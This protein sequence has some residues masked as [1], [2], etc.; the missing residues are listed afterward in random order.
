MNSI[1]ALFNNLYFNSILTA[2]VVFFTAQVANYGHPLIGVI[3]STFP[4]GIMSFLTIDNSK[5]RNDFL[6]H[7]VIGNIIISIMWMIISYFRH[8]DNDTLAII[9]FSSWFLM[10]VLYLIYLSFTN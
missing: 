1:V 2:I 7:I 3:L 9:G 4:I 5:I 10:G 8:F 6:N